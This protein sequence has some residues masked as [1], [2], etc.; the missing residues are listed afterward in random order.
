MNSVL[1]MRFLLATTLLVTP[2]LVSQAPA[3]TLV[4]AVRQEPT[5]PIP[6]LGP[7]TTG[8]ADVADQLFLRLAALGPSSRT[9]GDDAMIPELASSW[10]R[11]NPTTV[12]FTIDPRARWHDGTP[13]TAGDAVFA[14]K[15]IHTPGIGVDL[16][17]FAL[18]ESVAVTPGGRLRVTFTEPSSEQVYTAGF[19]LQPL[20]EH[21]LRTVPPREIAGSEF[22]RSPI[23]NGPFRFVRRVPGRSVE[24]RANPTFFLGTPGLKR[25]VFLYVPSTDAQVNL[26]LAGQTDVMSDVPAT[27]L[28]RI[29]QQGSYR[30]VMAPG[31]LVTYIL[32][33]ATVPGDPSRPHPI[34]ADS[35]VRRALALSTDRAAIA[36]QAFGP[37]VQTPRAVQS[38]AWFWVGAP[39]DAGR[40]DTARARALF[41]SAGWQDHDGDGV[42]DREGLPLRLGLIYP[43]QSSVFSAIAVQLQQMWR[44]VGVQLDLEPIDG[45]VWLQ[46]RAAGRFDIDI[47]G[48]HQDPSPSSLAQSWSCASA[49]RS[50]SSN[51]AH[52]CDSEFDR[53]R[54][55]APTLANPPAGF[56]AALAR[57]AAWQ[58][59]ITAAAPANRVAV[60]ERFDHV[61]VRSSKAWTS[62][63]QWRVKPGAMLPRDR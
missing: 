34:L 43:V 56:R 30:F 42:L 20:P 1:P 38:Q 14:W 58:P 3:G 35:L 45:P 10:S 59:A 52:W 53:L 33:N 26:L 41:R 44:L 37:G 54:T 57:M 17:A 7:P 49:R 27:A 23:G 24:L 18:I 36:R 51:I 31:N 55:R 5:A 21:L 32:F 25:L 22:A 16:A 47:A 6:Y 50:G 9:T 8:N 28:D 46:R 13:V 48:A 62:L 19:L 60:H 61:I 63:W 4:M 11:I 12:D 39:M 2:S 29:D 15:V 40:P